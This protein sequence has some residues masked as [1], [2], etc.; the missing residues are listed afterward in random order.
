[1][2]ISK[3]IAIPNVRRNIAEAN[4]TAE[5]HVAFNAGWQSVCQLLSD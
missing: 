2:R 5:R 1:M 3:F 4:Q